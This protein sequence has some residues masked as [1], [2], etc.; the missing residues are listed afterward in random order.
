MDDVRITKIAGTPVTSIVK[1]V[2]SSGKL[3]T[4]IDKEPDSGKENVQAQLMDLEKLISTA[5]KI[6]SSNNKEISFRLTEQGEPAII[7]ISNR[8]TGKVIRQIPSEEMLRLSDNM[9]EFVG[10]IFNGR[11]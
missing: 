5:N 4:E 7:I 11:V 2:T 3:K 6:A 1:Q 10:M 8:E 9:E